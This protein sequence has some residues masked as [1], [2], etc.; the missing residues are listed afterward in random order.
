[1][2]AAAIAKL[3]S[4]ALTPFFAAAEGAER[5]AGAGAAPVRGAPAT[6]TPVG[7]RDAADAVGTP[8][9]GGRG[10]AG[11]VPVGG[12]GGAE[13]AV[14]AWAAGGGGPPGGKVGNLI[15]AV[16]LGGRLMRTVS[17]LG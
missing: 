4:S 15:V 5:A 13:V 12:C 17:F 14:V 9:P 2:I 8:G 7:G 6:E 10:A 16:G 11:A 3:V 1:M